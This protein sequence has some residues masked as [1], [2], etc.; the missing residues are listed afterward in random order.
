M[1]MVSAF[2]VFVAM[3]LQCNL[4]SAMMMV[5]VIITNRIVKTMKIRPRL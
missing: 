1:Q 3:I 5:M 2:F 4:M